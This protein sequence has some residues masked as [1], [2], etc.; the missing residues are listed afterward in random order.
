[1]ILFV[2]GLFLKFECLFGRKSNQRHTLVRAQDLFILNIYVLCPI[3]KEEDNLRV[4]FFKNTP[5][6]LQKNSQ[7]QIY[8]C[9][10]ILYTYVRFLSFKKKICTYIYHINI[11]SSWSILQKGPSRQWIYLFFY[12]YFSTFAHFQ[13]Y[14]K[15]SFKR[16]IY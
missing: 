8:V 14:I 12:S 5:V 6:F 3:K 7:V 10:H 9:I 11:C 1:M 13:L 2:M 4:H 16:F 15:K